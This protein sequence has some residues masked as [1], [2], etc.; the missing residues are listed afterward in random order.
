MIS[1]LGAVPL[2]EVRAEG[3][4]VVLGK[5]HI[6]DLRDDGVFS[7]VCGAGE[8]GEGRGGGVALSSGLEVG[9]GPGYGSGFGLGVRVGIAAWAGVWG[10]GALPDNK[11]VL[12]RRRVM[13][14]LG[15]AYGPGTESG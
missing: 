4:E 9:P 8:G 6:V 14:C 10:W 5:E 12:A 3:F 15:R 13:P 1:T 11:K 7:D 2:V